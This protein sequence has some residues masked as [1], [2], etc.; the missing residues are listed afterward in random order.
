MKP[1]HHLNDDGDFRVVQDGVKVI[2]ELVLPGQLGTRTT[3]VNIFDV[4]R[5]TCLALDALT[6]FVK[7]LDHAGTDRSAA[8]YCYFFHRGCSF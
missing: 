4:Q 1:A 6:V 5:A 7:D 2:A 8:K 3:Q